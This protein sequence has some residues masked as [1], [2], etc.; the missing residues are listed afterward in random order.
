[1]YEAIPGRLWLGNS[2]DARDLKAIHASGIVAII[3]LAH[4]EIPALLSRDL[5]YCRFPLVD[6]ATQPELLSV[7]I[8]VT[9]A[10]I[11][12]GTPTLVACG[13]GMSRSPAIV[14]A[15]LA[16]VRQQHPKACLQELTAGRPHDVSPELWS[17]VEKIVLRLGRGLHSDAAANV[18]RPS[19]EPNTPPST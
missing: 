9:R 19:E 6:G 5:T 13:A 14:S 17:A 10:M 4:E 11:E 8:Q 7:A 12:N 18:G 16:I 15:A 1:M 2:S 3:D